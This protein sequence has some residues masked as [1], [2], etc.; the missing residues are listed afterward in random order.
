MLDG[1]RGTAE[2]L[3]PSVDYVRLQLSLALAET[4]IDPAAAEG[5][6][7]ETFDYIARIGEMPSRGQAYA[8]F[9]GELKK[10]PSS[11][12]LQSGDSLEQSCTSELEAVVLTLS[13]AT[14]DH[15]LSLGDIITGLA[16]G[17]IDKA[18]DYT[19]LVNTE[20]RRNLVLLDVVDT[21]LRRPTSDLD[22]AALKKVLDA[23]TGTDERDLGLLHAMD[24]FADCKTISPESLKAL[25]PLINRIQDIT[26]SVIACRSFVCA[27]TII[28]RAP[29]T[30]ELSALREH[31]ARRLM[32]RWEH[33][34][35]E[36]LRIDAGFGIVPDLAEFDVDR[37][38]ALLKATD[39][40][41]GD[42][43]ISAPKPASTFLAC[44]RLVVRAFCGLLPRHLET[45]VDLQAMA[46]L[47]DIIPSYGERAILWADLCMRAAISGRSDLTERLV[48]DY[49]LPAFGH[50]PLDDVA[51]R[52]GVLIQIAPAIYRAQPTTC[53]EAV[54][55]L[56]QEDRDVAFRDIIRFILF[57]R[58]PSDPVDRTTR[59]MAEVSHDKLLQVSS[60]TQ[61]LET[62]WMIYS[63][64]EDIADLL[65]STSNRYSL[66]IPQRED[67]A[68]RYN[69]IAK[70]RLPIANQIAHPGFRI[71]TQA[72]IMRLTQSRPA[73]WTD[74]IAEAKAL[75]NVADRVYVLQIIALALPKGMSAQSAK[76]LEQAK[77]EIKDIPCTLDQIERYL[78]LAEDVQQLDSSL[79]RDLVN[80]AAMVIKEATDD[81][82]EQQRRLV[83]LAYRVEEG[84]AKKLIDEFD[85]DDAKRRAQAQMKLL[86]IRNAIK[87]DEGKL[88]EE[89]VLRRIQSED[90]SQL[91]VLLLRSLN[92]GRVQS[93]HPSEIRGYLDLAA[94]QP[95]RRAYPILVW[96]LENAVTRFS[97]TP[98]ASIFLRPIFDACVV[99][100]QMAGRV[101]GR[102][103]VR[104]RA[105]KTQAA[106]LTDTR[107]LLATPTNREDAIR[108]LTTWIE[109][110]LRTSVLIHD[111]YFSPDDLHWVQLIRTAKAGCE[112]TVM[113]ARR[114]QPT[115]PHGEE[116]QDVYS[117][118]WRTSF[119]QSPPKTEIAVIG[120]ET[121]KEWTCPPN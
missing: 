49:C 13:D 111:P 109:Q 102:A 75:T 105:V 70:T 85:G 60:L 104:L 107:S 43:A 59:N 72:Q 67:I 92:S 17:D 50:V 120:G 26:D 65:Q 77:Q 53:I 16:P 113:T 74:L 115:P 24:R 31:V 44:I 73:D 23:I 117:N 38:E 76:L 2:R 4:V 66:N 61:R 89:K 103:M 37:A 90:V 54:L 56:N 84:L 68:R 63:T 97:K 62:D 52:A 29:E 20:H 108:I 119:D 1:V 28:A 14:A 57:D 118:A 93:Y 3:G 78:G 46:A 45:E 21:L 32:S 80:R 114:H 8:T 69:V 35:V 7:M 88:D 18:L 112:I 106:H 99:G 12:K 110:H 19:K 48:K 34:D 95:L 30:T 87:E 55:K 86:E 10:I 36:W 42:S 64:A 27:F 79:C 39:A 71:A 96:Y 94:E 5:R 15:Y 91:G 40:I 121:S 116:L 81:V 11:V 9:L 82:T 6:L 83:D 25:L 100:A 22:P 51:Y 101:A 41:K 47:I 33:I 98:Q 58:V